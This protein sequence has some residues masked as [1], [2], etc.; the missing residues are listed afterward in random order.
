MQRAIL[1]STVS[2]LVKESFECLRVN[3]EQV[4]T[5]TEFVERREGEGGVGFI[6][7]TPPPPRHA[8]T[9]TNTCTTVRTTSRWSQIPSLIALARDFLFMVMDTNKQTH[10]EKEREG[11]RDRHTCMFNI[12]SRKKIVIPSPTHNLNGGWKFPQFVENFSNFWKLS[13]LIKYL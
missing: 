2:L 13:W 9:H 12:P 5:S 11:D 10:I 4:S 1:I 7:A 3:W 6:N 8:H